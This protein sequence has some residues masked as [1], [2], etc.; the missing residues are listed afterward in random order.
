MLLAFLQILLKRSNPKIMIAKI[1]N[2][3]TTSTFSF[4]PTQKSEY[5]PKLV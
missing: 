2:G 5:R 4:N 3:I 1:A